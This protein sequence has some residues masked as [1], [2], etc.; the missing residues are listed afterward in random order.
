MRLSLQ[1]GCN[2]ALVNAGCNALSTGV[3][4]END[5]KKCIHVWWSDDDSSRLMLLLAYLIT[6]N[7]AWESADIFLLA[8]NYDRD[9]IDN[10]KALSTLLE[11]IRIPATPAII[12]GLETDAGIMQ[13][14]GNILHL[15]DKAILAVFVIEI[16]I[17]N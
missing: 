1:C 16:I 4:V 3:S 13:D 6:R 11:D 10:M 8:V 9:N 5:Q 17:S 12:L 15:A 2:I 14:Y 7:R